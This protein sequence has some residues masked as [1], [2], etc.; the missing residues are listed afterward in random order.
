ML[1]IVP[2][3]T[4]TQY[5]QVEKL[6]AEFIAMDTAQMNELALMQKRP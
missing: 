5:Q 6:L 1:K 4:E 2:A 3:E